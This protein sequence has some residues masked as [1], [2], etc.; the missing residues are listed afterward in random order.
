LIS[1]LA[2]PTSLVGTFGAMLLLGYS[3]DNLS[4]LALTLAVGFVVDDAIVVQ[5]NIVRYLEQ[6]HDRMQAALRGSREIGFTVVSMTVSLVAVFIPILFM[7]GIIGRL[8][9]EF[10]VTL[11][12]AVMLSG[13]V[14]LTLTPMLAARY[15]QAPQQHGRLYHVFERTFD[16]LRDGYVVLLAGCV[17][18]LLQTLLLA[19]LIMVVMGWLFGIVPKGFIPNEDAGMVMGN[20]EAPEGI[21]FEELQQLQDRV[22][23][24]VLQQP[25]VAGVMSSAGQGRGGGGGNTG[26]LLINLQPRAERTDAD[27][28]IRQLRRATEQVQG[29]DVF[30]RNPPAI[31]IGGYSRGSTYRYVLQGSDL[32]EL[33]AATTTLVD[34]LQQVP[35]L[36]DVSSD[37]EMS[38][39]Q[40]DVDIRREH[41]ATLGVSTR[42][43]QT[44]LYSAY[45][46]RRI[47]T[48]F[49]DTDDYPVILQLAPEFQ[50]DINALGALY[51]EGTG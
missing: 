28:I 10:A 45:G 27:T 7:G 26:F 20:T 30:F 3:L 51:I 44:A 48:I 4:L 22:A 29:I 13:A 2:L 8:F 17:R 33:S 9:S 25:G 49:G 18:H 42:Q 14:A 34:A 19:G 40:I 39:P 41:A 50:A 15:L 46:G 37:M 31:S 11:G 16:R 24:I 47:S 6:G 5:E 36:V 32:D 43:I 12:L 1:A 21:T 23:A 35:E 38:N